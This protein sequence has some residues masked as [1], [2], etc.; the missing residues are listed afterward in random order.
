MPLNLRSNTR[1]ETA[2]RRLSGNAKEQTVDEEAIGRVREKFHQ[3]EDEEDEGRRQ[4][5]VGNLIEPARLASKIAML[6]ELTVTKCV[7]PDVPHGRP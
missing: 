6:Q 2:D 1:G 7:T 4:S 5:A 3:E